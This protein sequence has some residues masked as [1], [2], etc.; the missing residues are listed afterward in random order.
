MREGT[1]QWFIVDNPCELEEEWTL[2]DHDLVVFHDDDDESTQDKCVSNNNEDAN[3]GRTAESNS[4]EIR[5][6][7]V[8]LSSFSAHVIQSIQ[9]QNRSRQQCY[10]KSLSKRAM[11]RA[12][13]VAIRQKKNGDLKAKQ[14]PMTRVRAKRNPHNHK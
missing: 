8:H 13:K 1:E 2:V 14:E 12:N 11:K 9:E 6:A 4:G 3:Y 7:R 10:S 5:D